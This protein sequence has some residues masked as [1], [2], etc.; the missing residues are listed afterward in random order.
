[1][2]LTPKALELAGISPR[3][4]PEYSG[5]KKPKWPFILI[6]IL[7]EISGIFGKME[8]TQGGSV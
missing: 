3:D 8:S 4:D 1:M 7:T 2:R 6:G 5:E